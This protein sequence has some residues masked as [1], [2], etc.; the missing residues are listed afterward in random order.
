MS[1]VQE[2][3]AG[4]FLGKTSWVRV[5]QE[6]FAVLSCGQNNIKDQYQS[7]ITDIVLIMNG[8]VLITAITEFDL[9]R[10]DHNA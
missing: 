6:A 7:S 10:T 4:S 1:W 8:T 5:V 2:A 9:F 3:F